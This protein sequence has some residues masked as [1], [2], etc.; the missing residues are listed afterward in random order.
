MFASG[1]V[2]LSDT[3]VVAELTEKLKDTQD[4][5]VSANAESAGR[6][7]KVQELTVAL[8]AANGQVTAETERVSAITAE[9]DVQ[10]LENVKLRAALA[11]GVNGDALD[12][13]IGSLSGTTEE[14][15]NKAAERVVSLMKIGDADSRRHVDHTQGL[16]AGANTGTPAQ[17]FADAVRRQI[18]R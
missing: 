6:R 5:L 17:A 18:R 3:A 12:D 9:R 1:G 16:G 2:V 4:R 7:V 10:R 15:I 14:E 8:E 11:A 13:F